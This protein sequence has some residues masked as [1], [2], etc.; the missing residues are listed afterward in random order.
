MLI[1]VWLCFLYKI[2]PETVRRAQV[3]HNDRIYNATLDIY[4]SKTRIEAKNRLYW[5]MSKIEEVKQCLNARF[6]DNNE[7]KNPPSI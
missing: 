7:N 6:P 2:V 4:K 5:D 3:I 1:I